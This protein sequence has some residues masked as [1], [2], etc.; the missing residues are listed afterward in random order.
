MS[1]QFEVTRHDDGRRLDALLRSIYPALPLGAMMKFFRKGSVRLDGARADFRTKVAAG[2]M[3]FVPWEAPDAQPEVQVRHRPLDVL[4]RSDSVLVIN[5]PAGLLSQP[6]TKGEDSVATRALGY[7]SDPAF[8]AQ[9]VHRLDRN[10]S[11]VMILALDGQALRSLMVCF[12]ERTANKTYLAL[13]SGQLPP[14]GQIDAPLLKDPDKKLVRVALNG[15]RAVTRFRRLATDGQFSL[16][17]VE[18]LTGRTHQIRV[19]MNHIGHPI[20]GDAKYG[21]FSAKPQVRRLGIR[22]PMLHATCLVVNSP[23]DC[24][25]E[26]SGRR[27]DAPLAADMASV[28]QKLGFEIYS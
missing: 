28:C 24:L 26:I 15:E 12:K 3:V 19:H 13:V 6:D 4:Y 17:E 23:D 10:T 25:K 27:F 14:S 1:Y 18:I 8:G 16:A 11:G 20:L 5:K 9:L 7:A 21:D 2:Q 22:R